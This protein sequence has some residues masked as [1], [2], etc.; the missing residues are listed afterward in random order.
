MNNDNEVAIKM[1]RDISDM[2][3]GIEYDDAD[4]SCSAFCNLKSHAED[5]RVIFNKNCL[6]G[7][8]RVKAIPKEEHAAIHY[9]RYPA[10]YPLTIGIDA[11]HYPAHNSRDMWYR[12]VYGYGL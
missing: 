9:T 1:S 6:Q 2:L 4:K 7:V 5:F 3:E 8:Y 11:I 12:R 10:P